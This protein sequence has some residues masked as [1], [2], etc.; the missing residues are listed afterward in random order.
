VVA[1]Q[2]KFAAERCRQEGVDNVT[3]TTG[4]DD[5][6]L[7]YPDQSFDT[8]V[9]NLVIE[10]CASRLDHLSQE[11]AQQQM[12]TE[13]CRVLRPNGQV[14]LNTKNR[15]SLRLL[16]G[17]R[18]EHAYKMRFGHALPTCLM[19]LILRMTGKAIPPPGKLH[20]YE[21]IN[22][23]IRDA[24]FHNLKTYWLTPSMRYPE[25]IIPTDAPAIRRAR[26]EGSFR[27]GEQRRVHMVTQWMPATLVRYIT[28]G[29]C[30]VARRK[31]CSINKNTQ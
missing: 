9:M 24:G 31:P 22:R 30:A 8:A 29:L 15:F 11:Q 19:H 28:P 3:F 5:C 13:I 4:G 2:A 12:I 25:R 26:R 1:L 7:P 17:G 23:M 27:Q 14:V 6:T 20:S 18:D 16:M 10:W 21:K